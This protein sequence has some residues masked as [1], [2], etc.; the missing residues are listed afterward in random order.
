MTG[1]QPCISVLLELPF[2]FLLRPQPFPPALNSPSTPPFPLPLLPYLPHTNFPSPP[3]FP[4][5]YSPYPSFSPTFLSISYFSLSPNFPFP[6]PPPPPPPPPLLPTLSHTVQQLQTVSR[7]K[8]LD[9]HVTE[10]ARGHLYHPAI[11]PRAGVDLSLQK[12]GRCVK[13]PE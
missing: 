10:I 2:P 11:T 7:D 1:P 3:T 13:R 6:P 12:V 8:H 4:I 9:G 5:S